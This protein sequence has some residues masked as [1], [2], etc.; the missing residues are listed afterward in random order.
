MASL[1]RMSDPPPLP[2]LRPPSGRRPPRRWFV[3]RVPPAMVVAV[4]VIAGVLMWA[5]SSWSGLVAAIAV[6]VAVLIR[7]LAAMLLPRRMRER[8]VTVAW[9]AALAV[10]VWQAPWWAI[11][12]TAG[13]AG[14]ALA[15]SQR[16]LLRRALLSGGVVLTVVGM[17]GVVIDQITAAARR[18]AEYQR[19]GDLGRAQMLPHSPD[20]V[21]EALLRAITDAALAPAA[22]SCTLLFT[23][24]AQHAV[25]EAFHAPDCP[26]GL[27]ALAAAVTEPDRYDR[28]ERDTL[29]L[30]P[31]PDGSVEIDT[32]Q[33]RWHSAGDALSKLLTGSAPPTPPPG[34][35]PGRLV[36]SPAYT[37]AWRITD[38]HPCPPT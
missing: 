4:A 31:R 14:F 35:A 22:T 32:C 28:I 16:G 6:G 2:W 29:I 24:H 15:F 23:D 33:L 3:R 27:R 26:T 38:Y 36:V 20:R 21:P 13:L 11:V 18:D 7:L 12:L 5:T 17:T 37:V 30:T 34:P 1:E 8:S 25:S 9:L 10:L 19:L